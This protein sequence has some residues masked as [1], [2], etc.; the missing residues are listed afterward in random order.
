MLEGTDAKTHLD[1]TRI[2]TR[3][4][5]FRDRIETVPVRRSY[6]L[7]V[8]AV[9]VLAYLMVT[10]LQARRELWHDELYTYYIA[11]APSISRLFEEIKLDLNPPLMYLADRASMN[12]FGDNR[13]AARL[14]SI[15]AFLFG[16]FCFYAFVSRRLR[17]VYGLLAMFFFWSTPFEYYATEARPYG[18]IVGFFGLAMVAWQRAVEPNRRAASVWALFFA[19][20]GMMCSHFFA[21][22]YI[23]PFCLAELWRWYSSRKFDLAMWVALLLPT[24]FLFAYKSVIARYQG[25]NFPST[26]QAS[27]LKI[28]GFYYR[29]LEP[30]SLFLLFALCAGLVFMSR[31]ERPRAGKLGR[32]TSLEWVVIAGLLLIPVLVNLAIMRSHGTAFPRY[33][34]PALFAVAFLFT[35]LLGRVSNFSRT[36]AAAACCV[37]FVY[38]MGAEAPA[39]LKSLFGRNA[40][41]MH[42]SPI[43]NVRPDLPLVINSGL[44]FLEMDRYADPTTVARLYYLTS[45]KFAI[46][47]AHASI[48]QGFETLK[49]YFPIRAAVEP[50][51]KFVMEHHTFLVLGKVNYPEDWLLRRLM[52]I[53]ATLVYLGDYYGQQLYQVTMP[54]E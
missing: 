46:Q 17:P 8:F 51:N 29:M 21:V 35:L 4:T 16:S 37:L 25:S 33:S 23:A 12:I 50:Y 18:L 14:P 52:D 7:I 45:T 26:A 2:V 34:G 19:V 3:A 30:E 32:L 22:I 48:F 39:A 41:T 49:R 44:S 53:H 28:V 24:P 9:I 6:R 36:A 20:T 31:F 5:E 54:A 11:K 40:P 43:V 13:Y 1:L 15:I 38:S 27:P 47:Y 10:A 42:V